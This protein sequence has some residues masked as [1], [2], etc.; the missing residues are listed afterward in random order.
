M[1]ST[2]E[3]IASTTLSSPSTSITLSSIPATYTDLKIIFNTPLYNGGAMNFQM[4]GDTGTNYS[5]AG[6]V[7]DGSGVYASTG[8]INQNAYL[9][10]NNLVGA[11]TTQPYL[12]QIDLFSYAGS[13]FKTFLHT[14]SGNKDGSGENNKEVGVYRSTSAITSITISSSSNPYTSG[15]IVTIY[16]ILKA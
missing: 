7:S 13:T 15:T 3:P 6:L 12:H 2:Y 16:G 11:T 9:L 1:P 10:G 4:N 8:Q 14:Y 5:Y